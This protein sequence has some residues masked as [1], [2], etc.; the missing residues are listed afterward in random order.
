MQYQCKVVSDHTKLAINSVNKPE[1]IN[2]VQILTIVCNI[3]KFRGGQLQ[4]QEVLCNSGY[5]GLLH[6]SRT[7]SHSQSR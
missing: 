5:F 7:L 6:M 4:I 1:N 3:T 2:F